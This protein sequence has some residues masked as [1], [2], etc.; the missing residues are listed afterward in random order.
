MQALAGTNGKATRTVRIEDGKLTQ[1]YRLPSEA[2][3][4][5]AA[6]GLIGNTQFE[7]I[8][9]GKMYPWNGMGVRSPK[10]KT[11][12]LILANFKRG[13]GDNMGVGGYLE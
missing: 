9:D 4:E 6:L 3:W 1:G 13:D 7:N 8:T 5:Y 11:R 12:G 2:E 10:K